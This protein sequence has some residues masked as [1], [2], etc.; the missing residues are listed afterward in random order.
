MKKRH[1]S[2]RALLIV[3]ALFVAA[4]AAFAAG[5]LRVSPVRQECGIIP[6]GTPATMV[7]GVENIGS[8]EVRILNVRTN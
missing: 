8:K 5:A 7:A 4:G 3:L 6:E 2:I 1:L